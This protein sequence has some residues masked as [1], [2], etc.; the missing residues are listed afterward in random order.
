MGEEGEV[1]GA[2]TVDVTLVELRS[3]GSAEVDSDVD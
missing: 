2:G 3:F 1:S